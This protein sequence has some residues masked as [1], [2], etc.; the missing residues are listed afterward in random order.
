MIYVIC[1]IVIVLLC[2][3]APCPNPLLSA[4]WYV[5]LF[6]LGCLPCVEIKLVS[7]FHYYLDFAKNKK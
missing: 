1:D 2:H 7:N 5:T 4:Y 6:L 3:C